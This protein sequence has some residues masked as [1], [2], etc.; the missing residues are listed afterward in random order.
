MSTQRKNNKYGLDYKRP[1]ALRLMPE[2]R[3]QADLLS[4]RFGKSNSAFARDAYLAG[5]KVISASSPVAVAAATAP[6]GA[7]SI[8]GTAVFSSSSMGQS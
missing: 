3:K 2:E 5:I 4:K 8:V 7:D 6:S 1:I